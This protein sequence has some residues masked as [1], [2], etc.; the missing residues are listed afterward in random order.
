VPARQ[1]PEVR[2]DGLPLA[3]PYEASVA[4]AEHHLVVKIDHVI[5]FAGWVSIADGTPI[6]I[7]LG[8]GATCSREDLA[9]ARRIDDRIDAAHV[10]CPSWIAAVPTDRGVLVARC[11]SDRCGP[12]LE[13]R[14]ERLGPSGPPQP[15]SKAAPWPAWATWALVGIG[16]ATATSV[17]LVATGVFEQRPVEPRFVVGGARQE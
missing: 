2:L 14:T 6:T 16:T 3:A 15:Q 17:A 11:E 9:S 12:L 13:W 5:V 10:T 8:N 4:A 1:L 7:T